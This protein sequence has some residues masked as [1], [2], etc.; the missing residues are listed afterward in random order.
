MSSQ[1]KF[2]WK[3]EKYIGIFLVEREKSC[4]IIGSPGRFSAISAK[5]INPCHAE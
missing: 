3:K 5:G 2:S 4:R 1:N